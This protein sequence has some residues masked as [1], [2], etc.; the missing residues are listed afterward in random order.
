[1][2]KEERSRLQSQRGNNSER[3]CIVHVKAKNT[4]GLF[5]QKA[6]GMCAVAPEM[7]RL[8]THEIAA[9]TRTRTR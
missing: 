9:S 7:F 2:R 3:H 1:M 4:H 8:M 5:G 6:P